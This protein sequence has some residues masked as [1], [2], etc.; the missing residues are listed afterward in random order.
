MI[1]NTKWISSAGLRCLCGNLSWLADGLR[2][3]KTYL[4]PR[5]WNLLP[6]GWDHPSAYMSRPL[7]RNITS[8]TQTLNSAA[9]FMGLRIIPL[10][11]FVFFLFVCVSNICRRFP[12]I[13]SPSITNARRRGWWRLFRLCRGSR[14]GGRVQRGSNKR[15][16]SHS[17]T[18]MKPSVVN[19]P[20]LGPSCTHP[21]SSHLATR[22]IW[23]VSAVSRR[24]T[25]HSASKQYRLHS[26]PAE[27][28]ILDWSR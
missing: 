10:F 19:P 2:T 22:V 27:H 6:P 13:T 21:P 23:N 9:A 17:A 16:R 11:V 5:V 4:L 14:A 12:L 18:L 3:P 26:R 1:D 20:P 8:T 24:S 25:F 7:W 28:W 15:N